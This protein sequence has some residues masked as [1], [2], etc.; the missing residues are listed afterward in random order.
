MKFLIVSPHLSTGG[1]PQYLLEYLK[2]N[3]SK[4]TSIKVVEFSNFSNEYII[5]REKIKNLIGENN[6]VC[7]GDFWESDEIFYSRKYALLK[8]IEEYCP[9]IIWFNEFPECFEYKL[10]PENLLN[11]IYSADRKYK[12][13]ETTHSNNFNFNNKKYIPDEFVFCSEVH[14][15]ASKN[16]NIPKIIWEVPVLKQNRPNRKETLKK[17]NLDPEYLHVLNVGIFNTN[18]N[19]KYIFDLAEK[20]K[21]YKIFFHFIG[22]TCF[23]EECG[24]S[25]DQLSQNNCKVWGERSDVDVFM[26]C[27]DLFLFPSIRELN[28]LS[29]K[30]ALS[31]GMTVVCKKCENYTNQYKNEKDFYILDHI[32]IKNL[33]V[34]KLKNLTFDP[35]KRINPIKFALYT[36][37]YNCEKYVDQIFDQ[38]LN[39]KY[40]DFTWFIT[41]DFSL[42]DTKNKIIK[43]L[44]SIQTDKIKY[45]EQSC[46]KE[47]YWQPNKFIDQNYEYIVLVDADDFFDLNFLNIY[48]KYLREDSSIFL[49]TSDFKKI[50]EKSQSTHSFGFVSSSEPLKYRIK[51]FH[52]AI[53]Y[54]N[55]L[56][57]YCFGTLRCFKNIPSFEFVIKDFNACG[58]DS[59]RAMY[60]NSYGKWLH[61]PRNL[62]TWCMRE[63]SESHSEKKDNFNANFE[64]AYQKLINS[65]SLSDFRFALYY[66]ET[67]ALNFLNINEKPSISL[68]TKI[69][70]LDEIKKLYSDIELSINDFSNHDYYVVVL[71]YF[72]EKELKLIFCNLQNKNAKILFYKLNLSKFENSE[73]KDSIIKNDFD[74]CLKFLNSYVDINY[75]FLYLRHFY[76]LTTL[77]SINLSIDSNDYIDV[78]DFDSEKCKFYYRLTN[79]LEGEYDLEI[80]DDKSNLILHKEKINLLKNLSFWT[81]FN[82]SKKLIFKDVLIIFKFNNQIVFQKKFCVNEIP[83]IN[84]NFFKNDN[85]NKEVEASPYVEVF[86]FNQYSKYEIEVEKNDIVVDIGCN[87]GAFTKLALIK[88]AK[89]IFACEPNPNCI[90]ILKK[91]YGHNHNF[92]LSEYGISNKEGES[93]LQ[94]DVNNNI[95]GSSTLQEADSKAVKNSLTL[96]VK[97]NTFKKFIQENKITKI[98]YLKVDCEGGENFIF[99][100]ENID[101]IKNN[102]NKIAIEYHNQGKHFIKQLLEKNNFHVIDEPLFDDVGFFYVKNKSFLNKKINIINE[103]GSLGDFIAW[104]PIV[105]RYA[106]EKNISVD[107]YTPY[108]TLFAESYPNINFIDYAEKNKIKNEQTISI[109]C[110]DSID[111]RKM[112]LQQIACHILGLEY[113]EEIPILSSSLKKKNNFNKKYVCIATQSTSQCK[114]WNNPEG[115]FK[116]IEYLKSLNYEVVCIDRH[117]SFGIQS[118]MN[119]IPSNCINKTGDFALE[120]RIN[121]LM[122]CE[123]FIGLGSGLS[124]LAWACG[125]PV[126]MISGFSDPISEFYTP[127]RVHNKNVC[128]SCWNDSSLTFEKENWLWCP[129]NKNFECSTQI[130]FE[131]VKEKIDNCISK[132]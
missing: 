9:D 89:S 86:V 128:N 42:D 114:Y 4:Y 28:P 35:P 92:Y 12:I 110:F 72:T 104:T 8:I 19:Q 32:N 117:E 15:E 62:Y 83:L 79:G 43:K 108:K 111:W 5:Q 16:I 130:S 82:F 47:M 125:K 40:N 21:S 74:N 3:F 122:H 94:V 132:L 81:A 58:E 118:R 78:F 90:N 67:C 46:K 45:V 120:D 71:N 123:F 39:I 25:K 69:K 91:Y 112:T 100:E 44:N 55:N 61:L 29:V 6:V 24:I 11:Q 36:S 85:F 66:K 76:L 119:V 96:P 53:D 68:F 98:D 23:L 75:W 59:Y 109:G 2:H 52:P 1:S 80:Y 26:S 14:L 105:S 7:L 101:F 60:V 22:N 33:L 103:S 93:Y 51:K 65:D 77:K 99:T 70:N 31:W 20:L 41:D 116:T 126:V 18:K 56:N 131:M 17:L 38:I 27:M 95:S 97:I 121:D 106:L 13:L 50:E 113:K 84:E 63:N 102:V 87:V 37:F 124:W 54:L 107:F 57:Y 64:I 49:L 88:E 127:Y 48:D 34:E 30:E 73:L 10:P 115:W 129:R